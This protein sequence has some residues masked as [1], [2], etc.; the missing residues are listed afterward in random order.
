MKKQY[1]LELFLL[2]LSIIFSVMRSGYG[3]L[4]FWQQLIYFAGVNEWACHGWQKTNSL[5]W[6]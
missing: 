5:S 2:E 1:I 4:S 3:S 6:I